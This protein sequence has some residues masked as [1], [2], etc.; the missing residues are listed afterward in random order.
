MMTT[1][2]LTRRSRPYLSRPAARYPLTVTHGHP[3]SPGL[4][5]SCSLPRLKKENPV[6][7][8]L[9]IIIMVIFPPA[10]IPKQNLTTTASLRATCWLFAFT[11]VFG[12]QKVF[13]C[14]AFIVSHHIK[15][16][17]SKKRPQSTGHFCRR[18]DRI[19]ESRDACNFV[20]RLHL[21]IEDA[22]MR[23]M[24][25]G[26]STEKSLN[27]HSPAYKH[28]HMLLPCMAS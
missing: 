18:R 27:P 17:N 2:A 22:R 9:S 1:V 7:I 8:I 6:V 26:R 4:P 23:S 25:Q 21:R 15:C 19:E 13:N 12:L 24:G 5:F 16:P 28:T 11:E 3:L 20:D 10:S 14:T